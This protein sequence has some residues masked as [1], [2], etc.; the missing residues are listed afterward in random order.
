MS[1]AYNFRNL[2]YVP[3]DI[4]LALAQRKFPTALMWN[5]LEGRPRTHHFDRALKAE[6]RDALWML[7]KQWQTGEFKA[8]DAGSPVFA[9]IHVS[10][11]QLDQYKADSQAEQEFEANVP[12]EAKVEQKKIPFTKGGKDI[13]I[14]LRLQMGGYWLKMLVKAGLNFRDEYIAKYAFNLPANDRSAEDIY[15]HRDIWQQYAAISGRSMDGYKFYQYLIIAGNHASDDI[16]STDPGKSAL[17]D[18]G[19][20]FRDWF[21]SMYYQP[22]DEKNNAW[23]PDRLEYQFECSATAN[24]E[25]KLIKGEE[26]YEGNLDWYAFDIK[27]Q[28]VE[29]SGQQKISDTHTFIPSHVQFDGMPNTRWWKFEDG[30]TNLGAIQPSTTDLSKLVLI[31]FGLV[32]ANDWFLTPYTLP[33]GSL[34]N[35]EGLTV[36]NNFGETTWIKP[37]EEAGADD[38]VW[39]MFKLASETQNNTLLLAP[40]AIKVHEGDAL[41]EIVLIR[42]EMSNMVWGIETRVPGSIGLGKRGSEMALEVRQ[43]HERFVLIDWINEQANFHVNMIDAIPGLSG[44]INNTTPEILAAIYKLIV[45]MSDFP[46]KLQAIAD[47]LSET[48]KKFDQIIVK[49]NGN[50]PDVITL[51]DD[52]DKIVKSVYD[53]IEERSVLFFANITD[54]TLLNDFLRLTGRL[55]ING[56]A[57]NISYLAMTNVP[58][59]WIP[60]VPVHIENDNR[61]IQL[62]R[63]SMLRIIEGDTLDPVKIKPQTSILRQGLEDVPKPSAYYIHEEEIPRAGVRVLQS[64][65]RTRWINGEVFVWL[66]MK[67]KT[68]RGEGSSGLAFDQIKNV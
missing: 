34:A 61:E 47:A 64:F 33:I 60:F 44:G 8:D 66:G 67:K 19:L 55:K 36:R 53:K 48:K 38:V 17:D 37:A 12:L 42:D 54:K 23:L 63:A 4:S 40:S 7:T 13:S 39:S 58:E 29:N 68:G 21:L 9:K 22:Q 49:I 20:N 16:T 57:A 6:V 31:E 27:Q 1:A 28:R 45:G 65:Q 18:L 26:Y 43:F 32:F 2:Q 15:S 62:Q 46:A 10:T 30:K 41:E 35:V 59:N 56:Y 24:N 52:L 51:K 50:R 14:D 11:S 25:N 3:T 5:R